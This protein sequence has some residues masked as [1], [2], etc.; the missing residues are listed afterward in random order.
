MTNQKF[1][2]LP[3]DKIYKKLKYKLELEGISIEKQT[4]A[5]TSQ[6]SPLQKEVNKQNACKENRIKRGL[7]V[8]GDMKWNADCVGAYNI[9]RLYL[10]KKKKNIELNPMEIKNPQIIKVAV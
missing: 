2:A 9:L 10:K 5:Y 4:E 8:D 6:T 1:H 7:Y 3:Y